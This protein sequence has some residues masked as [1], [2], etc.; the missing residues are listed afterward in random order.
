M[1]EG[2]GGFVGGKTVRGREGGR[3][4]MAESLYRRRGKNGRE[5]TEK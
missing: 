1:N 2:G 4:S 5:M 3:V